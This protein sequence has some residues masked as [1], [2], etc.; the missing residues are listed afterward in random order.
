MALVLIK[1]GGLCQLQGSSVAF[2]NSASELWHES[3][4]L[5]EGTVVFV[6][7]N[8]NERGMTFV[9]IC[10]NK[11]GMAFVSINLN[12]GCVS[13]ISNSVTEGGV[14]FVGTKRCCSKQ[15]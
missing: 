2:V 12:K 4:S 11:G 1:G 5:N 7:I 15:S 3:V 8:L 6:S 10:L 14:P 13:F 9:S